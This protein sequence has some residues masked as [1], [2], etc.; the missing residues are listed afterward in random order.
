MYFLDTLAE[1]LWRVHVRKPSISIERRAPHRRFL[2]SRHPDGRM[3]FLYRWWI[4]SYP[5]KF[6][7]APFER[8][9]FLGP[10]LLDDLERFVGAGATLFDR[11]A[12]GLEFLGKFAADSNTH[13]V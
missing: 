12:A 13:V 4:Q 8:D 6:G 1:H 7:I 11:Y 10:K 3:R 9:V 2:P 5:G